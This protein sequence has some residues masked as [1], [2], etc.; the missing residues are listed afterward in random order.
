M[1]SPSPNS[2][3]A[4][5]NESNDRGNDTVAMID[6]LFLNIGHKLSYKKLTKKVV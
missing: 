3:F 5:N 1:P 6:E 2:L 4:T